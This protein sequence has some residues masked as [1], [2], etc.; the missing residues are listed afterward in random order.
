MLGSCL[1]LHQG[2]PM[3]ADRSGTRVGITYEA[4][5]RR[6]AS[7]GARPCPRIAQRPASRPLLA[8]VIGVCAALLGA[9][10]SHSAESSTNDRQLGL[11]Y[12]PL[13]QI[14]AANV[15]DLTLAWE[16]HTGDLSTQKQA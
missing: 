12:S 6:D 2:Q 8:W 11:K 16:Y 1:A 10:T 13:H 3:T 5:W 14:N 15:Q 9:T 7:I 4:G